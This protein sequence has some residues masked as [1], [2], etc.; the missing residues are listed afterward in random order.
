MFRSQTQA[1]KEKLTST[2]TID[3]ENNITVHAGFLPARTKRKGFPP[4]TTSSFAWKALHGMAVA[5]ANRRVCPRADHDDLLGSHI[6]TCRA[7]FLS[8][9]NIKG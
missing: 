3:A 9:A 5:R 1:V 4:Q 7:L 2:F 8:D 6:L